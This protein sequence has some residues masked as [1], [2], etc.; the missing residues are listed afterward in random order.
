M[1]LR[2]NLAALALLM[3]CASSSRVTP[4]EKVIGLLEDLKKEVEDEGKAEAAS[5][6]KFACFCKDTT[7]KKSTSVKNGNDQ[8]EKLSAAI[9]EKTQMKEEDTT[10][11][12]ERK[13]TQQKLSADL[14]ATITRCAKEKAE[15]EAEAADLS[16]A[17]QG[18]KDALK[19]MKDSKPA[20]FLALRESLSKAIAMAD[21]MNVA[22]SPKHR[23]VMALLQQK[24]TVDPSDPEYKFHSQDIIDVCEKLLVEYRGS[25]KDLD[26]EFA[27]TSKACTDLKASLR[28]KMAANK[29]AMEAL[30]KNIKKLA[31]EIA[32]H[33]E[34]LVT[35]DST[36]KDDELYLKDLTA[37]CEVRAHDFD[38][39]SAMRGAEHE[40]LTS[41]LEVLTKDVKDRADEVN[42]RALLLQNP[43]A[44]AK[45]KNATAS[46]NSTQVSK[47]AKANVVGS[48]SGKPSLKSISLLQEL[49]KNSGFLARASLSL[50]ARKS[51]ALA[52][53]KQE[54]QRIGSVA[55]MSLAGRAAA[56]PFK[57]VKG[58]IQKLIERLLEESK[59][60][61]T[62]KG[63]CDTELGKAEKDRDFRFTEAQDLA[64]ELTKLQAKR[65]SLKEEIHTLKGDIK[66][67][68]KALKL[69][70]KDRE[71]EKAENMH[72]LKTAK[73][74]LKSVNEAILILRTFYKQKATN[75]E[76]QKESLVQASPVDEDT[77]GAGFSGNYRGKQGSSK[78]IFALLETIASDFDRTIRTTEEEE[79]N[80]HRDFIDYDQ[81]AKSSI[82]GKET[83]KTLDEQDLETTETAIETATNDM[84][85]AVDLLDK[86]LM[87]LE[88][89]KPTCMDSGMSYK[90]RVAKR[91]EEMQA[92]GVAL[93]LLDEEGVEPD[94]K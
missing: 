60:E 14:D 12:A 88:E 50:E 23:A 9:A 28:K 92:L 20:S 40:A 87:E 57:K 90:E 8:I 69:T 17:I 24:E 5:Y 66:A 52:M 84:K 61:A 82:A 65:D 15:Y 77:D 16:K 22:I 79:H 53:L 85:T 94:C 76:F 37:R 43:G 34:D 91:E 75:F 41:A 30:D 36:L 58:L 33:R 55:L 51:S 71:D 44:P 38:Q 4:I 3:I 48:D 6:D 45:T 83:K 59:A 89:L 72:T 67:E 39:R 86:A 18:L 1:A 26:N 93:C 49:S 10:E 7:D 47:P 31:K 11:L 70:T 32:Q 21:V 78:A 68:S 73:E 46:I 35:A 2:H 25:K 42:V 27:K 64:A 63:F 62:K 74:G 81:A 13:E 29:E 80:S 19:A 54:G 56:D